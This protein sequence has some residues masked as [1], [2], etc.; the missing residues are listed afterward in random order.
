MLSALAE[1]CYPRRKA[2]EATTIEEP[3]PSGVP[4][5]LRDVLNPQELAELKARVVAAQAKKVSP[6]EVAAMPAEETVN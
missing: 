3:Q 5:S 6:G 2:V 1:Y 4:V